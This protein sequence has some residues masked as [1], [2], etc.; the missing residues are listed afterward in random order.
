MMRRFCGRAQATVEFAFTL[1]V[2]L[3]LTAGVVDLGR[4]AWAY[5]TVAYL[6]RDGARYG[7]VPS[8]STSDIQAYVQN[9]CLAMLG[10]TCSVWSPAPPPAPSSNTAAIGVTRGT[11][12]GASPVVVTVRYEAT[13]VLATLWSGAA[14]VPLQTTSRMYVESAP[15]GGCLS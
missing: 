4:V 15:P 12:G 5:N 1:L 2:F 6:A 13:V 7:A 11:C 9:R 8:H 14:T 10:G 3:L